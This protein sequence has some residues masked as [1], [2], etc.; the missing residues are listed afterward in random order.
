M[1]KDE[2]AR[3]G[4]KNLISPRPT[5]FPGLPVLEEPNQIRLRPDV[6]TCVSVQSMDTAVRLLLKEFLVRSSKDLTLSQWLIDLAKEAVRYGESYASEPNMYIYMDL[7]FL[8]D[9]GKGL[10]EQLKERE[11]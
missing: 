11:R 7:E 5:N 9:P 2:L 4:N 1:A 3:R 10:F 8:I 6:V